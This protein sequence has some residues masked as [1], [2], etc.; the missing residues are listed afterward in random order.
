MTDDI[1]ELTSR[2]VRRMIHS[3]VR[4]RIMAGHIESEDDV[5]SLISIGRVSTLVTRRG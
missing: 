5:A 4:R 3:T 1:P 2:D